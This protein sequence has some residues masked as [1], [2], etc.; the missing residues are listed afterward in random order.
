MAFQAC[1]LIAVLGKAGRFRDMFR[2]PWCARGTR[3]YE[4]RRGS[5]SPK[6]YPILS[7][8]SACPCRDNPYIRLQYL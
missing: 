8:R 6:N 5:N 4:C 1:C 3:S 2:K 7:T